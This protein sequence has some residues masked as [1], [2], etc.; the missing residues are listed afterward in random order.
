MDSSSLKTKL[1]QQDKLIES[2]EKE[3]QILSEQRDKLKPSEELAKL[4]TENQKLKY[5]IDILKRSVQEELAKQRSNPT[6]TQAMSS[7]TPTPSRQLTF[8]Y[9]P[10]VQERN[11][12]SLSIT[13]TLY[14]LFDK[15][16]QVEYSN[17]P[18]AAVV[19]TGSK[20]A[21]YQCN[22]AMAICQA[23]KSKGEKVNPS[24]VAQK[25]V[26][27][28]EVNDLIEKTE[29][30]GPGFINIYL[31][32]K[33]A[34]TELQKLVLSGA[35]APFVGETKRAIVDF[36]SPN[37]AKEMHVG[38]LRSTI[39]GESISRLLEYFGYD[40]L[41]LNHLGDW[42]TQFGMLIAHLKDK[43]PNYT[44]EVPPIGD[45]QTFYKESKKRF[46][47][48]EAFK[49]R[50]YECVVKLQKYDP[51]IIQGWKLICDVSR[52][53]FNYIYKE[54]DIKLEERGES[55]YQKLMDEVIVEFEKEGLVKVEDGR[56]LVFPPNVSIPLTVVKSDG[57][58]T[59]D[60]SDLAAIKNRLLT[61]KAEIALYVID[62]GQ[63]VHMQGI[64]SAARLIGWLKP[65]HRVEHVE[66]GVVLGEDKKKFKTRSGDTVRL[67]DLLD[68]GL[69]RALAKLK[70]KE[71]DK[72]LSEEELIAA[73]KAIA[74]GCV[75]YADLSHNR[76]SEYI[77]SF[78]KMLE[79]KGN[80]A[81]YMLYAYTRIRSI[82]RN[83]GVT[84]EQLKEFVKSN[85]I[86]LDDAKEWKLAKNILRFPE[87]YLKAL[88]DL[89]LHSI[90]DYMYDL[91][92]VFT[93]FYD[94]CYCIEKDKQTGEIKS[95]NMSRLVLCESTASVLAQ[96][97][98]LLGLRT[99][100][101]M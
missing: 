54:L 70:E 58:Y 8:K 30:S 5:R 37:I 39:I 9:V 92:T 97:F 68:E 98:Y 51:E 86:V 73:Q 81:V 79:D 10:P 95:V 74:Y 60:T 48:D 40:V 94:S 25:I 35:Q 7:P 101:K 31:S 75:K 38:H 50:A 46:D 6:T 17:I 21:D 23:L 65:E 42:G 28:L 22:S 33:F 99:I 36:S 64:F 52:K 61:E 55:Y 66:F 2:L 91:A 26:N 20:V 56:K 77:F 29:V 96:C 3:F 88:N 71:R 67:R 72:V 18:E 93:E 12:Y 27:S 1:D 84:S 69:T 15:A 47:E 32:K 41:R 90:C 82:A 62:A 49:T 53:E 83:A 76:T 89:L 45:L 43:F 63:S 24:Q 87:V 59:Y 78:D 14:S 100:E 11:K 34:Q 85:Q 13:D 57:G 4:L 80:T 16:I 19:I 44:Q